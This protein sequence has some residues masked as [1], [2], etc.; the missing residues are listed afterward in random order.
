MRILVIDIETTGFLN[1]GGKIVEIGVVEL[2]LN[3]GAKR[4][5]FNKVINPGLSRDELE[6][7]WIVQNKYITADEILSGVEF[8]SISKE[9]QIII[10]NYTGVT[11][12]NKVFDINFL[13][14]YGIE[15]HT[16]FKCPMIE[17]TNICKIKKTGKAAFFPGYKWPK[18]EEA[19]KYFYPDS[20]YVEIHRGA[21]DAF[22]EAD[23]V[24]A[25]HK[26]NK[27][28]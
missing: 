5:I 28:L 24:L 2:C 1:E 12:F 26:L 15:F 8:D 9:L 6:K 18:V 16:E 21:D 14:S 4:I 7:T 22:Y 25:L 17:S 10:K 19:Y 13:K 27:L 23:I 11:A 20:N 3:S